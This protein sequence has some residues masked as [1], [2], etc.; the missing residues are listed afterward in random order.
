MTVNRQIVKAIVNSCPVGTDISDWIVQQLY[1][2]DKTTVELHNIKCA[3]SEARRVYELALQGLQARRAAA[4]QLCPHYTATYQA[5]P[6]G[7]TDS[8][9]TCDVCGKEL[10]HADRR[11]G[12]DPATTR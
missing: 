11:T 8:S 3:E 7:G 12:Q 9:H 10:D 5:D 1:Q 4:Q 2:V 6:A